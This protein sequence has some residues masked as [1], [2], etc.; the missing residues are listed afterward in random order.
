MGS[1]H[2]IVEERE[3]ETMQSLS[4]QTFFK[5]AEKKLACTNQ[6]G[7]WDGGKEGRRLTSYGKVVGKARLSPLR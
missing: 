4:L 1:D 6:G 3:G 2:S 7:T 5:S